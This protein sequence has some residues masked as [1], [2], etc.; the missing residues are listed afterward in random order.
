MVSKFIDEDSLDNP[1]IEETKNRFIATSSKYYSCHEDV[2]E[3][4]CLQVLLHMEKQG[5]IAF[6][7]KIGSSKEAT[8][9]QHFLE[10][11]NICSNLMGNMT[12]IPR[13]MLMYIFFPMFLNISFIKAC[14]ILVFLRW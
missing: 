13:L 1:S 9:Q 5:K 10:L 12:L 14:E 4:S 8:I 11:F 6:F 7:V 3:E 2:H